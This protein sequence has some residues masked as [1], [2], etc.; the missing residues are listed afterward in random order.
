M[1]GQPTIAQLFET[2]L[3]E[4]RG[5]FDAGRYH[6]HAAIL[7]LLAA[8]LNRFSY[9]Q[10]QGGDRKR[11]QKAYDS[12]DDQAFCHTFGVEELSRAVEPF[13]SWYLPKRVRASYDVWRLAGQVTGELHTWL[14]DEG[15]V[16]DADAQAAPE[17]LREHG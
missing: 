6:S 12:G 17:P 5:H 3:A 9:A 8:Y 7:D 15:H 16:Q 2:Y 11:W 14:C 13:L 4:R 10:L 1:T